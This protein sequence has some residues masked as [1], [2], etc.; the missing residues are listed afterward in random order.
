MGSVTYQVL[1]HCSALVV[2]LPPAVDK[3]TSRRLAVAA[4]A[5]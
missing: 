1:C 3:M 4:S 5:V 2:A